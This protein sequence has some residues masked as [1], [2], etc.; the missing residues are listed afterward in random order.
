MKVNTLHKNAE[1]H[2]EREC[3]GDYLSAQK[4]TANPSAAG[5]LTP[6]DGLAGESSTDKTA[7]IQDRKD[8]MAVSVTRHAPNPYIAKFKNQII[9]SYLK[10][11]IIYDELITITRQYGCG[12]RE[13][14][15][16][17]NSLYNSLPEKAKQY[18]MLLR[19]VE[20]GRESVH[21][22][23]GIHHIC[24]LV[25]S[26]AIDQSKNEGYNQNHGKSDRIEGPRK[27]INNGSI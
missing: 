11:I 6:A 26:K 10:I 17:I 9:F 7:N 1:I 4:N 5:L 27:E 15:K 3:A 24:E 23:G 18:L 2:D 22:Q 14:A 25:T 16:L 21:I 13:S 12:G 20:S 8:S 19:V